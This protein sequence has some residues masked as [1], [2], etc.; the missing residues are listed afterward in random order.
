[1]NGTGSSRSSAKPG[2]IE[3]A[4]VTGAERVLEVVASAATVVVAVATG[5]IRLFRQL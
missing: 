3:A 2:G 4:A 5:L 1:V